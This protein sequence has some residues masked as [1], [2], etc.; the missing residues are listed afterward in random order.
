MP[1]KINLTFAIPFVTFHFAFSLNTSAQFGV[2]FNDV[3]QQTGI[4]STGPSYGASWGDINGDKKPD[5]YVGNHR[6]VAI[7]VNPPQLYLNNG[8]GTFNS[9]GYT[10]HLNGQSDLHGAAFAD[11]DNDGDD[12]LLILTGG[13]FGNLFYTNNG[14]TAMTD[15]ATFYGLK[16]MNGRG[17]TPQWLDLNNDGWLDVII[18]NQKRADG[19]NPTTLFTQNNGV[20]TDAN[21]AGNF[22]F[23]NSLE[24]VLYSDLHG[25]VSKNLMFISPASQKLYEFSWPLSSLPNTNIAR[26][27]DAAC[28]DFNNDLKP[29]FFYARHASVSAFHQ[30]NANECKVLFRI[31][32]NEE[33]GFRF[34]ATADV[35]FQLQWSPYQTIPVFIGSGGI[36]PAGQ[37]FQLSATDAAN[38][39]IYPHTPGATDAIYIGYDTAASEWEIYYSAT[40]NDQ[41]AVTLQSVLAITPVASVGFEMIP[42]GD[43]PSLFFHSSTGFTLSS[44]ATGFT[45]SLYASAVVA[46]DF[47]NDMDI[48]IFI[49]CQN[50]IINQPNLLFENNGSGYFTL[51]SGS[52]GASGS[53]TGRAESVTLVD[54]DMDGFLDLYVTNGEGQYFLDNAPN[55]LFR[56]SGNANHWIEI[57]LEGTLCNRDAIGATVYVTA[58]GITQMREHTGGMHSA[59][60]N[61]KRLHFGLGQN[62]LISQIEVHWPD[63]SVTVYQNIPADQFLHINQSSGISTVL[64]D[65]NKKD[66]WNLYPNPAFS[67]IH[68]RLP[69][70]TQPG[71]VFLTDISGRILKEAAFSRN[72]SLITLPLKGM[73]AGVYLAIVKT[74]KEKSVRKFIVGKK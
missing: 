10:F 1:N 18:C 69:E 65:K 24:F 42:P 67:A 31:S 57:D 46:G 56:N 13:S 41:V 7:N 29:D 59:S 48:D 63:G 20:F 47:D 36:N 51:V 50:S 64:T 4:Q 12:D 55:Q 33:Q 61:F 70:N 68:I 3:T 45:D 27:S 54:Y 28:A 30:S 34:A 9:N 17:R 43:V 37:T 71:I 21:A 72:Q 6:N 44:S 22:T 23:T 2:T 49:A 11:F 26:I 53:V 62:S 73:E 58:G 32:A 16:M 15:S 35:T 52:A 60:Q 8:N 74:Q 5:L 66:E 40:G 19:T 39:G 14:D 25:P 38:Y